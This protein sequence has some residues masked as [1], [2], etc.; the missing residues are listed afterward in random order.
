MSYIG[1]VLESTSL[2]IKHE[3]KNVKIPPHVLQMAKDHAMNVIG[4]MGDMRKKK[5]NPSEFDEKDNKLFKEAFEG[6]LEGYYESMYPSENPK[7]RARAATSEFDLLGD[8]S[9]FFTQANFPHLNEDQLKHKKNAFKSGVF[10]L[11]D[12]FVE[13]VLGKIRQKDMPY[14]SGMKRPET[15]KQKIHR[16][17]QLMSVVWILSFSEKMFSVNKNEILNLIERAL[18]NKTEAELNDKAFAQS[19]V[20]A[21]KKKM[22]QELSKINLSDTIR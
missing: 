21:I 3:G 14:T 12:A 11:N 13:G 10:N 19:F 18:E 5:S 15:K 7:H 20:L 2:T 9:K 8:N 4:I 6:Y 16:Y 1:T 17:Y 22:N